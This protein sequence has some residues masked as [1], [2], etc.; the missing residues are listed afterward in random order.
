IM[1]S[2]DTTSTFGLWLFGDYSE[3]DLQL[4]FTH[5]GGDSHKVDLGPIDWAGWKLISLPV[6][7]ITN[8]TTFYFSGM[9][10]KQNPQGRTEGSVYLDDMQTDIVTGIEQRLFAHSKSIEGYQLGANYPNPFNP[11]THIPF[12]LPGKSVITIQIYNILGQKVATPFSGVVQSGTHAVRWDAP[13][14]SSGIYFYELNVQDE[15]VRMR[16]K[17]MLLK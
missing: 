5:Q 2:A 10:I 3:N 13:A 16:K 9:L 7:T 6:G 14:L 15:P 1:L 17:M 12:T 8:Q 11:V 4:R